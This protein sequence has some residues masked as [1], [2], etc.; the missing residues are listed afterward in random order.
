MSLEPHS[1]SLPRGKPAGGRS[2][3]GGTGSA[4][5]TDRLEGE[6][7]FPIPTGAGY[8]RASPGQPAPY[9]YATGSTIVAPPDTTRS[10]YSSNLNCSRGLPRTPM[11]S[12]G[13]PST[14]CP[15]GASP[16]CSP[17]RAV[18]ADNTSSG[19]SAPCAAWSMSCSSWASIPQGTSVWARSVPYS[20]RIPAST[21]WLALSATPVQCDSVSSVLTTPTPAAAAPATRSGEIGSQGTWAHSSTPASSAS[22]APGGPLRWTETMR[23]CSW[24]ASTIARTTSSE[25]IAHGGGEPSWCPLHG[26]PGDPPGSNATLIS[27][28]PPATSWPTAVRAV[29]TSGTSTPAPGPNTGIG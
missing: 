11:R 21:S 24:A 7:E 22:L 15:S 17:A 5:V 8:Q 23:P 27:A 12:A 13:A 19:V 9:Q 18:A 2:G 25:S 4:H 3:R 28:A 6:S 1:R 16:R 10:G 20:S 26:A 14:S 29:W